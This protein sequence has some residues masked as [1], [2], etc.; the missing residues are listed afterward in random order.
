MIWYDMIWYDM[1]WYD[2]IWYDMIW[3]DMIWYDM[4]W[5]DMIWYDKLVNTLKI[6]GI[7][8]CMYPTWSGSSWLISSFSRNCRDFCQAGSCR[9]WLKVTRLAWKK[10]KKPW[11]FVASSREKWWFYEVRIWIL[12]NRKLWFVCDLERLS[13]EFLHWQIP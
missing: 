12:M 5:Y 11:G 7:P 13:L 8:M 2:M 3:Y 1:I 4:I 9:A 6:L 10:G